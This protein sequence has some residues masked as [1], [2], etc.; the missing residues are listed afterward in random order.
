MS[1]CPI[2]AK[3]LH[4]HFALLSKY[5]DRLVLLELNCSAEAGVK[6][7]CNYANILMFI[8]VQHYTSHFKGEI[9]KNCYCDIASVT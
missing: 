2:P 6:P 9:C 4:V 3:L 1:Y 8:T 5:Q 7:E